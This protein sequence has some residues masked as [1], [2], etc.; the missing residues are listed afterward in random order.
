MLV[1]GEHGMA[2]IKGNEILDSAN[3]V[4]KKKLTVQIYG[5][6]MFSWAVFHWELLYAAFFVS[7][8]KILHKTGL[9]R[10]E[11]LTKQF[12]NYHDPKFYIDWVLPLI[13]T[14]AVIWV[15]P[16][17]IILP[18]F[19]KEEEQRIE[20]CKISLECERKLEQESTRLEKQS[21]K[22][23]EATSK[24]VQKEKAIKKI[25]PQALWLGEYEQFKKLS[26]YNKFSYII[27]SVYSHAGQVKTG[28]SMGV[29]R[30]EVPRD[31]LVYADTNELVAFS[32]DKTK[33][34]LTN[35]GRMFV[36]QF[37]VELENNN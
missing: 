14:W 36:K 11:Y 10:N 21:I 8:D 33:I 2:L 19:R 37:T 15:F 3:V 6:F 31:I 35:K 20:K 32:A 24:K 23:L 29:Y 30:F 28:Y 13:L 26:I 18:A 5:V 16:K 1:I 27:D 34:S 22:K 4:L 12:F 9:L 7:E 17:Y 25:D